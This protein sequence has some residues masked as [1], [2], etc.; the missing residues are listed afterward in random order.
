MNVPS[1]LERAFHRLTDRIY[2]R[3]PQPAYDRQR[4]SN[5]KI[6]SHRG[7]HDNRT[8]QENTLSAFDRVQQRGI[9]G[10]EFDIRWT[11]DLQPVVFHDRD[12]QRLFGMALALGD[13]TRTE[14]SAEFPMIPSLEDVI[15]RYGKKLHLMVEIKESQR[16][17]LRQTRILRNLF[18]ALEPQ[19]DFHV[20]SLA[21][22]LF[23][24]MDFLPTSAFL[25]VAELNTRQVSGLALRENYAGMA[26]HYLFLTASLIRRHAKHGQKL[27]TG[28]ISS[29]NSLYRELNRGIEWIFSNTASQLQAIVVRDSDPD[30]QIHRRAR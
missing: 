24:Q 13:L 11:R 18:S 9:W 1:W 30:L 19:D 23:Q 5:C 4:L 27:G 2:A 3:L 14:L 22:A 12:L 20:L 16:D 8:V 15:C 7:E 21:P 29:R 6:V 25:P 17:P 10:V 28:Y 26:G